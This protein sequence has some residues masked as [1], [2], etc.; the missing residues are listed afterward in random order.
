MMPKAAQLQ[1]ESLQRTLYKKA[2]AEAHALSAG[3][4]RRIVK[5]SGEFEA[6]LP[7]DFQKSSL[8]ELTDSF[9]H[10]SIV[11][12]GDFHTLK[13]SQK[14]LVRILRSYLDRKPDAKIVIAMEAFKARDQRKVNQYLNGELSEDEFLN[15]INYQQ[16]W[17]FPWW[18][19]RLVTEF[20]REHNMPIVAINTD[21]AGKDILK[22]RDE[23]AAKILCDTIKKHPQ[24][25]VVCLIG[26]Y[27]LADAHLPSALEKVM[28]ERKTIT[29]VTR[30]VTNI[31]HYYFKL[32]DG[33]RQKPTEYLKLKSNMFCV[34]NSP[35]WIKWQS[36]A[37]WQ[38]MRALQ[39]ES[40][41]FIGDEDDDDIND[42]YTEESLDIEH[43]IQGLAKHLAEFLGMKM[44]DSFRDH[45]DVYDRDEHS[46]AKRLKDSGIYE[47]KD[48]E[49]ILERASLDGVYYSPDV[50]AVLLTD[51]SMNNLSEVSS[52]Y[53]YSCASKF[54][55][56]ADSEEEAFYRRVLKYASGML[57]SKIL[58]PRR[59]C[60]DIKSFEDFIKHQTRKRLIGHA[61]TKR[62]V[63][64]SVVKHHEF[65][66]KAV[67]NPQISYKNIPKSIYKTDRES[68]YDVSRSIGYLLGQQLYQKTVTGKIQSDVI[69]LFFES[70]LKTKNAVWN[71]FLNTYQKV[72][73]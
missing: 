44:K 35:P 9:K 58:N 53:L 10:P 68:Y 60:P 28:K 31:D 27:H 8:K 4:N 45:F 64:K 7:L 3:I 22:K 65:L 32:H 69:R 11:L 72:V 62:E 20:A 40:M 19:F 21:N 1:L 52:Q 15:A 12:Y 26:E 56:S 38:E 34:M 54:R 71:Y 16:E 42:L 66:A 57:G 5:Y 39:Q 47:T 30:I 61:R 63:A 33:Q 23:F 13:Q 49:R 46:F 17:G 29:P 67:V 25:M 36:Y 24:A 41:M 43:Q 2:Y 59:K 48:T 14:G 55:E 50:N 6:S 73:L 37:I 18:N 70:S 51:I